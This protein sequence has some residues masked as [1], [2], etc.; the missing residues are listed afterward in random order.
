M[1]HRY[2]YHGRRY[3]SASVPRRDPRSLVIGRAAI[4]ATMQA[5]SGRLSASDS[6]AARRRR[7]STEE[8]T[9]SSSGTTSRRRDR[10]LEHRCE[11]HKPRLPAHRRR[12]AMA[13][14]VI[15]R[16]EGSQQ[17]RSRRR[18][19]LNRHLKG[20]L[21][22]VAAH[23]NHGDT[24]SEL[25]PGFDEHFSHGTRHDAPARDDTGACSATPSRETQ[26]G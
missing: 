2:L 19:T 20:A 4:R 6:T 17:R 10:A 9:R 24:I 25:V 11:P 15:Q 23:A 16:L 5:P 18:L 14:R 1:G 26:H 22:G 12:L 13:A 8:R 21:I 7:I 3:D